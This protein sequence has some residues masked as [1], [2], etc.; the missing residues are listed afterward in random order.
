[1]RY[2][3]KKGKLKHCKRALINFNEKHLT[4]KEN[5]PRWLSGSSELGIFTIRLI[6]D[7]DV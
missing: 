5:W 1:M 4:F 2:S 7:I 3:T 6:S